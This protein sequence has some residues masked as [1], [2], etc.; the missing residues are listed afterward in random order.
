ML[1]R[2]VQTHT[3]FPAN[4]LFFCVCFLLGELCYFDFISCVIL[5]WFFEDQILRRKFAL[6]FI[7][8]YNASIF[9]MYIDMPIQ[10]YYYLYGLS[11]FFSRPVVF[12][13]GIEVLIGLCSKK[14]VFSN[15]YLIKSSCR[16]RAR[17]KNFYSP[18][19]SG[20][21]YSMI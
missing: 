4:S 21:N 7:I 18:L 1:S 2:A 12:A 15:Q 16:C 5:L 19:F 9:F 17:P 8:L 11:F 14:G 20:L 6:R 13:T 3:H 10:D